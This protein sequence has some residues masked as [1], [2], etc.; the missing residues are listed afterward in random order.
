MPPAPQGI[1]WRGAE[2]RHYNGAM[3]TWTDEFLAPAVPTLV[4]PDTFGR[5]VVDLARERVVRT[6]WALLAGTLCVNASLNWGSVSGMARW[7]RPPVGTVLRTKEVPEDLRDDDPPP[8]GDSHEEA[9]L[10]AAGERILDVLPALRS[11]PYG[12]RDVAVAFAR[13]DFGRKAVRRHF[14]WE[15]HRTPLV[16]FA[17]AAPQHLPLAANRFGEPDGDGPAHPVQTCVVHTYKH[18]PMDGPPPPL[19]AVLSRHLGPELVN[20]KTRG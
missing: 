15:D 18:L 12:R 4:A 5:L 13:M 3:G 8:W 7:D 16:A 9:R 20:G 1:R 14:W 11:A 10:L 19:A 2:G 6:P 17:L